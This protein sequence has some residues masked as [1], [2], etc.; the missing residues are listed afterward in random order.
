[1]KGIVFSE[2]IEMVEDVFS[3]E[4]ADQIISESD[5][6]SGGA[7]T[8]VGT[9]D[10]AEVVTLVGKLSDLTGMS[11]EDLLKAFGKHLFS[12]FVVGYPLFFQDVDNSFS[13]LKTL[14]SHI[15]VEVKKLYP[16]ADLP[17]FDYSLSDDG[18]LIMEYK[19]QR[20]FSDLAYGLL[21]GC[22]EH[23]KDPISITPEEIDGKQHVKFTLK[24][25]T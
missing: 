25:N 22:V 19:S 23:F 7:Y 10:H 11:T 4:I 14:D 16:D 20:A 9:Y 18:V 21:E 13:F 24:S 6:P 8:A 15:H 1:M 12:R 3:P 5:L 17:K 2:L